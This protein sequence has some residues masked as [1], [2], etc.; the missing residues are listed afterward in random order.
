[1]FAMNNAILD[2]RAAVADELSLY[3]FCRFITHNWNEIGI[4]VKFQKLKCA[5]G[6]NFSSLI[7]KKLWQIGWRSLFY[8][9]LSY[10]CT[11]E[12]INFFMARGWRYNTASHLARNFLFLSRSRDRQLPECAQQHVLRYFWWGWTASPSSK[13]SRGQL[14]GESSKQKLRSSLLLDSKLP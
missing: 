11:G 4:A 14:T 2:R 10:L 8:W 6:N 13:P 9:N 7:H 5:L 3:H 1:M 12:R